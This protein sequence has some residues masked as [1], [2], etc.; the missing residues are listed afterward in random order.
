MQL[1]GKYQRMPTSFVKN[2][3]SYPHLPQ[4]YPHLRS[5]VTFLSVLFSV[6]RF[7]LPVYGRG[8][9]GAG[10]F[11]HRIQV[12]LAGLARRARVAVRQL[13][14]YRARVHPRGAFISMGD[15]T[16]LRQVC[17]NPPL[18][19]WGPSPIE[20]NASIRPAVILSPEA[21]G[22]RVLRLAPAAEKRRASR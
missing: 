2:S 1:W 4:N 3:K 17:Y 18:K 20:I 15:W 5:F 14:P 8:S 21:P 6:P 22:N 12:P 10:V 7:R 9:G 16:P 19:K 11:F 13:L